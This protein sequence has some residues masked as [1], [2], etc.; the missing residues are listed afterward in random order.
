[1]KKLI[2][3]SLMFLLSLPLITAQD[4]PNFQGMGGRITGKILNSENNSPVEY[5]NI[6]IYKKA[7]SSQVT[8]TISDKDGLFELTR[9]MPGSYYINVQFMGFAKKTIDDVNLKMGAMQIDL[10]EIVLTADAIDLD[11]VVVEG[12]R[13]TLSYD[14]DKK[15][16]NL[17]DLPSV[18]SGTAIDV[19]ENVPSITVDIEGNVSLRGSGN[20]QVLIDG[21]PTILESQEAL[22]QLPASS[23]DRIEIITNPS[24]KYD[25]SGTAGV[26]NVILK[27][28][29]SAGISGIVNLNAGLNN[30]YGGDILGVYKTKDY[31]ITL[32]VDYNNRYMPGNRQEENWNVY[33]GTKSYYSSDGDF[34]FGFNGW[35][36]RGGIDINLTENDL[37][38]INA[39]YRDGGRERTSSMKYFRWTDTTPQTNYLSK[40]NSDESN[41]N[42]NISSNYLH[43]FNSSGHELQANFTWGH[44]EGDE[45]SITELFRNSVLSEG[46][47]NTETGPGNRINGKIEYKLPFNQDRKFE[48]GFESNIHIHD[49]NSGFYLLDSA[50]Q[51]YNLQTSYSHDVKST[52]NVQALYSLYSNKISDFGFQLGIRG[53]YTLQK[54]E[55]FDL[56][57]SFK[58]DRFDYFPSIH[59]SYQL[60]G[61]H[62]VMGSYARRIERSRLWDLE[63][64]DVWMDANNVRR[65]NPEL[66][67]EYIDSYELGLQTFLGPVV[68]SSEL[69]YRVTNNKVERISSPYAPNVMLNTSANVG[70]DYSLGA[71]FLINID[72]IGFW[73]VNLMGNIYNY[74]IES[75][76]NNVYSEKESFNWRARINNIFKFGKDTQLQINASYDSPTVTA[77]GRRE[78]FIT[79]DI[80]FRQDFM[81]KFLSLILQ[82]RDLFGTS[83]HEFTSEGIDFYRYNYFQREAP[84]VMLN[85]KLNINNYEN[86]KKRDRTNTED[87]GEGMSDFQ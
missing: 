82:I 73:N 43:K 58:I 24:A 45:Y 5:A 12:Q 79:T 71:E 41:N 70:K 74:K 54:I 86:D 78:G 84:M 51:I 87:D 57:Q 85:L 7:D 4:R 44:R 22:E 31:S 36:L 56:N 65:G 38:G 19:L 27:K 16:I 67:P 28:D 62:Q 76:I 14:I 11:Q 59:L 49:E 72:P 20:F 13:P 1:M 80:A 29:Q 50:T 34:K 46:K 42:F 60:G 66:K 35:G 63:P 32:G 55:V 10:G 52:Q 9:L 40:S 26:I 77:Q 21:R 6:I 81:N 33:S 68:V 8:G 83:N 17:A 64:F 25:P 47:K 15:V 39:R 3:Y 48:A 18:I 30:K 53:E 61:G 75:T 2:V 37:L 69:Y 23:I